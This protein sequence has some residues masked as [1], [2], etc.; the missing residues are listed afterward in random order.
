MTSSLV[1]QFKQS[2]GVPLAK[3]QAKKGRPQVDYHSFQTYLCA[4]PCRCVAVV[5]QIT[6]KKRPL[7]NSLP[8]QPFNLSTYQPSPLRLAPLVA[9]L[10]PFIIRNS[11]FYCSAVPFLI[12][13]STFQLF[14]FPPTPDSRLST[15][16]SPIFLIFTPY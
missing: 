3:H 15:P 8:F 5:H 4:P 6:R 14:N 2:P 1:L 11:L 9:Y 13:F 16:D 12:N 10:P 7:E